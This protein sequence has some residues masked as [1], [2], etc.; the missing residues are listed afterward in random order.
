MRAMRQGNVGQYT[1]SYL[2]ASGELYK[3]CKQFNVK[4]LNVAGNGIYTLEK[5]NLT[6]KEV[7]AY[8]K[9]KEQGEK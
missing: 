4:T 1:N 7:K 6:Q 5:H 9:S 2:L 8:I 3:A